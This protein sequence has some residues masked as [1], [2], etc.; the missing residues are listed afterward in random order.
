MA[1]FIIPLSLFAACG[2]SSSAGSGS[3]GVLATAARS[4]EDT[5]SVL[6]MARDVAVGDARVP[7]VVLLSDEDRT[8][9]DDRL[10][11]LSFNYRH[12]D[13]E[14]FSPLPGVVWRPWPVRGGAYTGAP[15]FSRPGVWEFQVSFDDGGRT[16][17]GSS[18][19]QV[20]QDSS[21]PGVGDAAPVTVTRTASTADEVRLISSAF[22]PDPAFYAISL[23]EALGNGRPTAVLFSTPAFCVTQTCGPQ[24][25]A[26]GE[27]RNLHG[28]RMDFIHVEIFDNIRE[29][30]DTGDSSIGRVAQPVK[31]WGLITEPWTFFVDAN[32]TVAAR[33][34]Q[35]TTLEELSEAAESVLSAS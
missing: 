11:N 7:I 28:D 13:E 32:G 8:R 26:L 18:F 5:L 2:G 21:A 14:S 10:S 20:E 23:D 35:F 3:P 17:V 9:L 15:E 16:R 6:L 12:A 29:M 22:V 31:D 34:E 24:L 4:A 25:E 33:F 27:L 19:L 1:L 30:L